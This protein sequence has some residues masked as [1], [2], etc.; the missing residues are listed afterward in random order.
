MKSFLSLSFDQQPLSGSSKEDLKPELVDRFFKGIKRKESEEKL[1]FLGVLTISAR[2]VVLSLGGLLLF[3]KNDRRNQLVPDARVRCARFLGD[4]KTNIL[5]RYEVE[6]TLLDAVDEVPKFIARNTRLTAQIR[7]IRRKDIP[8]YPLIAVRESLINALVHADYSI[9]G[10]H[11]QI[12]IFDNRLEI[13]NPGMLPFGFTMEDFKSGVSR[14]RNRVIARTFHE[15]NLMEEWGS[16]YR[17]IIEACRSGGY[18][19][20]KWEE[21]GTM[22][23]VTFFPHSQSLLPGKTARTLVTEEEMR[24]I[25]KAILSLFK[26]GDL[27]PFREIFKK[28]K[29]PISERS[30]RYSLARL[31]EQGLLVSKEKGRATMWQRS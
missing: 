2:R 27:L 22:I 14:I 15:L 10:S 5:D 7:E 24:E 23:R 8:E 25:E 1:R 30:L 4:D 9:T 6:G 31:K 3:G 20:P 16:G 11:I 29:P 19:E 26:K 28:I 17:R 12:A 13:Q 18:P 21:L